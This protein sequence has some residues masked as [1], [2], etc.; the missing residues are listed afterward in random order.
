MPARWL[1]QTSG[2]AAAAVGAFRAVGPTAHSQP[3][4][5]RPPAILALVLCGNNR[6]VI[7]TVINPVHYSLR[8]GET[9]TGLPS[10]QT[11]PPDT[12][13]KELTRRDR[14]RCPPGL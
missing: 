9:V 7:A 13:C 5:A 2:V 10:P 4:R 6:A 1:S 12:V 11:V 3:T 14:C 8:K